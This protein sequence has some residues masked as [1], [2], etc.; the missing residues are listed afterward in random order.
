MVNTNG[1]LQPS[2]TNY[3]LT[4]LFV[5]Y[6]AQSTIRH[7]SW[8]YKLKITGMSVLVTYISSVWILVPLHH[9]WIWNSDIISGQQNSQC[10]PKIK[11]WRVISMIL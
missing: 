9:I 1:C 7:I 10:V 2:H 5:E 3:A 8:N 11:S 6:Q 4:T